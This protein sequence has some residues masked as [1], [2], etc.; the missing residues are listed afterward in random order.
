MIHAEGLHKRF[1]T[2]YAVNGV[3]IEARQGEIFGLLGPNGAGKSTTIR[4]I[5]N[6]IR[7]DS[8]SITYSGT[9][10]SDSIRSSIGYLAE[11]RG[12]YQKSRIL[13][14]IV[15]FA[16]LRGVNTATAQRRATDWLRRF[17]LAGSE[18]RRVEELSKGNQQKVQ[19]IISLIHE[20][21]YIIL[22]EPSSGLDPVNQELL[23]SILDQLRDEGRTIL[24]STHQM[25]QAERLC[26]RIVLINKGKVVLSGTVQQVKEEHGGNNVV[27]E[28]EGDG[29]FL[30][31][32]PMVTGANIYPNGAELALQPTTTLN[33][34]LPYISQQLWITRLERVRPSLNSIF[35]ETVRRT[36]G[37]TIST[38]STNN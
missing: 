11:E 36:T 33:D 35:I 23:R 25:E 27:M 26:N 22:D 6:I 21:Q 13:E 19:L 18:R 38:N 10:F 8:G 3:T 9:P 7:P 4:M 16:G 15:H 30:R 28:F 37:E 20:P 2:I 5:T 12:L 1:A 14:T 24:Y 17:E 32:L 34:L 29:R 31:E